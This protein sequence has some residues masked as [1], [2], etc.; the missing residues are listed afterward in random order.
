M[1][2]ENIKLL[3]VFSC[4]ILSFIILSPILSSIIAFPEG[5]SFSELWL[6]Q[7]NHV[8]E[9][10]SLNVSTGKSNTV[11]LGVAN[12]MGKLEYYKVYVKFRLQNEPLPNSVT[13]MHS[14]LEPIFEYHLFL[15]NNGTWEEEFSFSFKD[16]SFE[17][18]ISQVSTLSINDRDLNMEKIVVWDENNMGFYCQMFF[19]LWIYNSITSSFQFHNRYVSLWLNL[20]ATS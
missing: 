10:G 20:T 3:Y 14:P 5:E 11:Y 2:F 13:E 12:H 4:I 19:E 15:P 6:L 7:S 17:R 1:N 9:S 8:I 16:V 18:N